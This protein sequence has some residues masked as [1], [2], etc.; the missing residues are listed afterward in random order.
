MSVV[1]KIVG[2]SCAWVLVACAS[3]EKPIADARAEYLRRT[4][5]VCARN[6]TLP[7]SVIEHMVDDPETYP[8]A[9]SW[10]EPHPEAPSGMLRKSAIRAVVQAHVEE[11]RTCFEDALPAFPKA[12]G[13][14]TARFGVNGEGKVEGFT[15]PSDTIGIEPLAC[16][17]EDRLR[18]WAFPK[19]EG[20]GPVIIT[21]PFDLSSNH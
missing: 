14:L 18:T 13:R 8:Y 5:A 15:I 3:S 6:R 12:R 10:T 16:C 1:R 4:Q 21:Y 11:V 19:P 20:G 17:V 2:T 7:A 9:L